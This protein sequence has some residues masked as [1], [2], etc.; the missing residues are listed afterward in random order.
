M[1][2]GRR[3]WLIAAV[4]ALAVVTRLPA[5]LYP[6]GIDDEWV[7]AAVASE[8]VEG[9]RPYVD[10]VERKPP[11]LFVVYAGVFQLSGANNFVAL[12]AAGL[13][14]TLLTM[15]G[16]FLAGRR[17]WG[18][19]EGLTAAALY[20]IYV[21]WGHWKNL[22][23]NGEML[24]NLP[25]AFAVWLTVRRGSVSRL[26]ELF[27]AGLLIAAAFL[28]KQ[29]AGI[30]GVALAA[31]V[32]L[33]SYRGR[34]HVT[35]AEAAGHA[36][37][38]AAGFAA[39]IG[40][41]AWALDRQGV[42]VEAIY[43]TILDHDVPHGIGDPVF[44]F[45]SL[46]T[47]VFAIACYPVVVGAMAAMVRR[48]RLFHGR[49]PELVLLVVFAI[50]SFAGTASSGRFY[51]HYYTQM[52]PAL[53]LLAAPAIAAALAGE[54][55]ATWE[56]PSAV[57]GHLALAVVVFMAL[58]A[59][60]LMTWAPRSE[61]AEYVRS[62]SSAGD[63]IFVWGQAAHVYAQAGRRPATRYVTT[64]PLTGYVFGSPISDD[65]GMD[66]SDRILPGSWE[67]FEADVQE[68][69]P[70]FIV[71]TREGAERYPVD[72]FPRL[73]GLLDAYALV[74]RA[75]DGEVWQQRRVPQRTQR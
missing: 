29:P 51:P 36:M 4:A 7:Y 54:V 33:P 8:M 14:W 34:E 75:A 52:L 32:L 18:S 40:A 22:A 15:A 59:Y 6:H 73:V 70:A 13:A 11:L 39:G 57:R 38:L 61:A 25:V 65:A 63:R 72:R 19:R 20:A 12:H 55:N 47:V 45:R 64:F 30:A 48:D 28:L 43:W 42:L 35:A 69:P 41:A 21:S 26:L 37:S 53:V 3:A 49:E 46:M 67:R 2:A 58:H 62:H 23:F 24:M 5:I 56:R 50:V 31:Y 1:R 44:W 27:A 66:T 10:A 68:H 71:L 9:G 17:M 74:Y 60:G 16:L